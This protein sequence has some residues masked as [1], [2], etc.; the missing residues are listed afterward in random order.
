MLFR[1]VSVID[2]F[3]SEA[4][5]SL[6]HIGLP[7]LFGMMLATVAFIYI[8]TFI[9]SDI[10]AILKFDPATRNIV[11]ALLCMPGL[12]AVW[13]HR[14]AHI[15]YKLGIPLLPRM[16]NYVAR[17]LFGIDIH[18]GATLGK[19][20]VIDH[21]LGTVIGETAVVGDYCLI[22]QGVTLGG[23]GKSTTFKRHPTV[24][25]HVVIG[26]GAKILGPINIGNH[27]RI[28][29]GSVVLHD[30]PDFCTAVGVPARV[31]QRSGTERDLTN[32]ELSHQNLPDIEAIAMVDLKHSQQLVSTE[33]QRIITFL[34]TFAVT[35]Y[36]PVASTSQGGAPKVALTPLPV[37][38]DQPR[39]LLVPESPEFESLEKAAAVS[40][41]FGRDHKGTTISGT[42][43]PQS[44]LKKKNHIEK[45]LC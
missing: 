11:E 12:H 35:N 23:T 1:T 26:C 36:P 9:P 33:F 8:S 19:G 27:V 41:S 14:L 5:C 39:T 13:A 4:L 3:I 24:G 43:L 2:T 31:I 28:G 34:Q 37:L 38:G 40:P 29:A 7:R 44:K 15:G 20:V 17:F 10:E 16:M 45:A 21:A 42:R 30:V 32:Q 25:S 22:Y 18:P 6:A